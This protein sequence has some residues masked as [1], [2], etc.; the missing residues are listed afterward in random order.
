MGKARYTVTI[1]PSALRSIQS[2]SHSLREHIRAKI[3]LLA[4]NP[5]PH[6]IKAL[7]GGQK[8][9]LRLRVGDYR[10]IYR[11]EDDRLLVLVVA[12]GHRREVY[13]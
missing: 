11:V 5:R 4:E 6:G 9:Y 1:V 3:D 8:G 13:R 2:L 7:Q 12:V 10:V